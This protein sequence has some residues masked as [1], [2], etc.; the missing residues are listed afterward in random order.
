MEQ[1]DERMRQCW[2]DRT[3]R[4][5]CHCRFRLAAA[6]VGGN[7]ESGISEG[8]ST[9]TIRYQTEGKEKTSWN[10][11]W[12]ICCTEAVTLTSVTSECRRRVCTMRQFISFIN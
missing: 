12:S 6:N 1:S 4:L 7:T 2:G 11:H 9:G 5:C 10:I 3:E 8:R